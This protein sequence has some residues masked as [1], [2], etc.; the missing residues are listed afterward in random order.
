MTTFNASSV[1]SLT[2]DSYDSLTVTGLA[3]LRI[4]IANRPTYEAASFG[5]QVFGPF[6][7]VTTVVLIGISAGTYVAGPSGVQVPTVIVNVSA[8]QIASP[9]AAMIAATNTLFQLN[10]APYT[11]YQADG[12][13]LSAV[14]ATTA[15]VAL[16]NSLVNTAAASIQAQMQRQIQS[17]T[18]NGLATTNG[19]LSPANVGAVSVNGA[20]PV[21]LDVALNALDT[22]AGS[23]GNPSPTSPVKATAPYAVFPGSATVTIS[24]AS[25]AVVTWTAHGKSAGQYVEFTT[26]GALPTGLSVGVV[27]YVI[28]AGLATNTFEVSAT[29]GGSAINTSSA[30]S[31]THTGW[32]QADVGDV[33][34]YHAG[35]YTGGAVTSRN[36][37]INVGNSFLQSV[38][39]VL[40]GDALPAVPAS[41]AGSTISYIETALW[42]GTPA[43]SN[44]TAVYGVAAA[45]TLVNV[46]PPLMTPSTATELTTNVTTPGA[47]TFGGVSVATNLLA[48][49]YRDTAD[50]T[51]TGSLTGAT[52]A[53]FNAPWLGTTGTYTV[54][55]SDGSSKSATLTNNSTAFSW[56]GA[57]TATSA[58]KVQVATTANLQYNTNN[59]G[60]VMRVYET[61]TYSGSTA[62]EVQASNTVTPTDSTAGGG[63]GGVD[64]GKLWQSAIAAT[65]T[66]GTPNNFTDYQYF[67]A[68]YPPPVRTN[69]DAQVWYNTARAMSGG[70]ILTGTPTV[71]QIN[72]ALSSASVVG[73]PAGSYSNMN[74]MVVVPA[75][76]TLYVVGG[77]LA[78]FDMTNTSVHGIQLNDG[79]QLIGVSVTGAPGAGLWFNGSNQRYYKVGLYDCG[80]AGWPAYASNG[81]LDVIGISVEAFRTS[82]SGEGDGIKCGAFGGGN[83]TVLDFHSIENDDDGVDEWS[84][85]APNF[86]HWGEANRNGKNTGIY[87]GLG[88]G[89]GFKLGGP[90][91]S[92]TPQYLNQCSA[93]NNG[94]VSGSGGC[95]LNSNGSAA[96]THHVLRLCTTSSNL[97]GNFYFS[98]TADPNFYT[99][100]N[101]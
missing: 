88:D 20:A 1:V 49:T 97:N 48:L 47:Y 86:Y 21:T 51:L 62:A 67:R 14:G 35:T 73:I 40:D 30:G 15:T 63:G 2:L 76:K 61:A 89:N 69:L 53:N 11:I 85:A 42:A 28:S 91:G 22:K 26:T 7:S 79:A 71:S 99:I 25:P 39:G 94:R 78:M 93:T 23:G 45:G 36:L 92:T 8:A 75:N 56:T 41:A 3:R 12:A 32:S 77:G 60:H 57:V 6:G 80:R 84:S 83:W 81:A 82:G 50:W 66:I 72:A 58:V 29:S 100:V 46:T 18:L 68:L 34:T 52:S 101:T 38:T 4:T 95:G 96:G 27:Y 98:N 10:V 13:T 70:T 37:Q 43:V 64:T 74:S 87:A 16:I 44:P 17:L 9:T 54:I 65:G 19:P 90:S 5:T 24:N 59:I 33:G 31:G 55:F